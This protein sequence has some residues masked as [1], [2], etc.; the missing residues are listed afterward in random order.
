MNYLMLNLGKI[1]FPNLPPDLRRRR[2][3]VFLIT[4]FVSVVVAGI[5]AFVMTEAGNWGRH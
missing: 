1:M 5:T 4:A 3:A 2:L